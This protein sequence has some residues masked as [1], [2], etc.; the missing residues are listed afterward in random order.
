MRLTKFLAAIAALILSGLGGITPSFAAGTPE[1]LSIPFAPPVNTELRY[2]VK[3]TKTSPEK[4]STVTLEEAHLFTPAADGYV[5]TIRTTRLSV[6][7]KTFDLTTAA[8]Q[9]SVPPMLRPFLLPVAVDLGQD[10]S[11]VRLRDW[12]R[13]REAM[14]G[15]PDKFASMEKTAGEREEM[16]KILTNA[17]APLL[18][19]TAEQAPSV[20]LKTWAPLLGYGGG[21]LEAGEIYEGTEEVP[22]PLLPVNVTMT[23]RQTLSRAQDGHLHY[24]LHSQPDQEQI[25]AVTARLLRQMGDGLTADKRANMEKAISLMKTMRTENHLDLIL[26]A[27]TGIVERATVEKLVSIEGVG[28]GGETTTVTRLN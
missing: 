10:G 9:Q 28:N 21:E 20:M 19:L 5:L 22:S 3:R 26:N 4:S 25:A 12:P 7:D 14:A 27:S 18:A 23:Q 13:L 17:F 1:I 11:L 8:G 16:R 24:Q 15:M 6:D 2:A